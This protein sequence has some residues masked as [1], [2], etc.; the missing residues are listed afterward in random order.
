MALPGP[1]ADAGSTFD[2]WWVTD[3][4]APAAEE[5]I[6]ADVDGVLTGLAIGLVDGADRGAPLPGAA[7]HLG[8]AD[9]R[10]GSPHPGWP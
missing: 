1:S 10:V 9:P 4:V 6:V 3:A 7:V 2:A 8:G 5:A